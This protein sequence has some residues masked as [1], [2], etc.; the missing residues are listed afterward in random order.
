[1]SA[2]IVCTVC[3]CKTTI[4]FFFIKERILCRLGEKIVK[5]RAVKTQESQMNTK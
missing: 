2:Y 3:V 4:F 5:N 1:M